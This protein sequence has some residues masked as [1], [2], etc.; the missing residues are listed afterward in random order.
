VSLKIVKPFLVFQ[1]GVFTQKI[2]NI[3]QKILGI[4]FQLQSVFLSS[5]F[6]PSSNQKA[7]KV[8]F[9]TLLNQTKLGGAFGRVSN[10][11]F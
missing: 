7:F 5:T 8:F 4:A 10:L 1:L 6:P 9:A 11:L 3:L 2:F